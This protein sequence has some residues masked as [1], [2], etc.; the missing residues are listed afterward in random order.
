VAHFAEHNEQ[1][2]AVHPNIARKLAITIL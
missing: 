1:E 2:I